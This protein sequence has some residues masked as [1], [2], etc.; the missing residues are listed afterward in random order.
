MD[1]KPRDTPQHIFLRLTIGLM[2]ANIAK[3]HHSFSITNFLGGYLK[4]YAT[5]FFY[6]SLV[7]PWVTAS[8]FLAGNR[9]VELKHTTFS[10]L[11]LF[12]YFLLL[13]PRRYSTFE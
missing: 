7:P 4:M 8:R 10:S 11:L 13:N 6:E 3:V 5:F 12:R 1:R 9:E 2:N